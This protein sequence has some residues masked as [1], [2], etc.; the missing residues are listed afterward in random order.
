MLSVV[1]YHL[2]YPTQKKREG[3]WEQELHLLKLLWQ[4]M[5]R[6][7]ET[8]LSTVWKKHIFYF[9]IFTPGFH[10]IFPPVQLKPVITAEQLMIPHF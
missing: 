10:V 5:A 8:A 6:K 9:I 4:E 1:Y 2:P 3:T 7:L